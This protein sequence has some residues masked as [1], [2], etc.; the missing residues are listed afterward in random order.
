MPINAHADTLRIVVYRPRKPS[1]V[2]TQVGAFSSIQFVDA[3]YQ[4]NM[5]APF[6]PDPCS[7]RNKIAACLHRF[8]RKSRER[9]PA[10]L[11]HFTEYAKAFIERAFQPIEPSDVGT[12]EEWLEAS[13]Y[14]EAR[15][16]HLRGVRESLHEIGTRKDRSC[17]S[18][19]KWEG[20]VSAK[21]ARAINSYS[22]ESKVL[23]G[24]IIRAVDKA[25]FRSRWFVKGTNPKNWS[26]RMFD[27]FGLDPVVITD[28]SSFESHAEGPYAE[29][30]RHWM[31]HMLRGSQVPRSI[32]ELISS[33]FVGTNRIL[34]DD[35]R[36]EVLEKLMSGALWTSSANGVLNLCIMSYLSTQCLHPEL[37][38]A[39]LAELALSGFV[40]LV[41]GDDGICP[42]RPFDKKVIKEM[43]LYLDMQEFPNYGA[44]TFCGITCE[45]GTNNLVTDPLKF[46]LNFCVLPPKY[47]RANEVTKQSLLRAKAL[48]YKYVFG[49]A[50]VVGRVCDVVLERTRALCP[51][52]ALA[53]VPGWKRDWVHAAVSEKVW[54]SKSSTSD[55]M[56]ELA[57]RTYKISMARLCDLDASIDARLRFMYSDLLSNDNIRHAL[58][59]MWGVPA[60]KA[61][62][63]PLIDRILREGCLKPEIRAPP[64]GSTLCSAG[65]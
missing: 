43:G 46:L 32:K 34:F 41:E 23:L 6:I 36:C 52:G 55:A 38:G 42:A 33:M 63:S 61:Y 54:L 64:V 37:P 31:L 29:I 9:D 35:I 16:K 10:R 7:Q 53:D 39:Q 1:F 40:G 17:K 48:S 62:S 28:F 8:G 21:V 25:T 27:T 56:F 45:P 44:G 13:S 50:P 26:Q 11:R 18:F 49:N 22:D 15:K 59:H 30:T 57:S 24:P 60:I 47:A 2:P 12:F 14:G 3:R 58:V 4:M 5:L 19:I 65:L 51:Y 20:Y